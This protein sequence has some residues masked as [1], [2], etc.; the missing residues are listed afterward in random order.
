MVTVNLWKT[1]T[2]TYSIQ[3]N[4]VSP[5]QRKEIYKI[6][7]DWKQVASGFHRDG[8][9]VLIFSK[10]LETKENIYSFVKS[11]P[12]PVT[13]EKKSGE[14]K[15]V[16]TKFN[17]TKRSKPLTKTKSCGKIKGKRSCSKCGQIG[18][19]SRTCRQ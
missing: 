9:E 14:L 5:K 17:R 16:K 2:N 13:E 19:N 10:T 8:S 4:K 7:E 6:V 1:E 3:F 18:H 12:F 11:M 15:T